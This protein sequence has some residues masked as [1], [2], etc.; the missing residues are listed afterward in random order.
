[1]RKANVQPLNLRVAL[2]IQDDAQ[3]EDTFEALSC[4]DMEER[5]TRFMLLLERN[6]SEVKLTSEKEV[7]TS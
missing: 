7:E 1:M 3:D 5:L 4:S 6:L 2:P